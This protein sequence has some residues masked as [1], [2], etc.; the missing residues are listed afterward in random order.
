MRD[1][2]SGWI[3][4]DSAEF[5]LLWWTAGYGDPPLA[6]DIP[7]V[8]RTR[9]SR[10]ELAVH[11]DAALSERGLGTVGSPARDLAGYVRT[12]AEPAYTL[13]LHAVGEGPELRA[14]SAAGPEG[15]TAAAVVDGEV[16]IGPV[17]PDGVVPVLLEALPPVP[18]GPGRGGNVRWADYRRACVDGDR[19]GSGAF[20]EALCDAGVRR[21]EA[22]TIMRAIAGR[23]GG[24]Q[25]GANVRTPRGWARTGSTVNWVDTEE[26]RYTIRRGGDWVMITPVDVPRLTAMAEEMLADLR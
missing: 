5:F 2:G 21:P 22:F 26:G 19:G 3:R 12:L 14:M 17:P 10:A 1:E 25:L 9:T 24:G 11:A 6:L 18:A 20:V 8:G 13:D 16:R 23:R 7:H 4:L 15:A